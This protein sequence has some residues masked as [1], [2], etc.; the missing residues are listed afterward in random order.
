M[1]GANQ[2]SAAPART[3]LVVIDLSLK[4]VACN[5]DAIQI[6]TFPDNPE[7]ISDL[8]G[9]LTKKI[10]SCL[11]D[12]KSPTRPSFVAEFRSANRMHLCRAFPLTTGTSPNTRHPIVVLM[13]ERKSREQSTMVEI[14]KRFGLTPREQETA[15]LLGEGLTSKEIATRMNISPNTVN[16]FVRLMMVKMNVSSR[17]AIIGKIVAP[18]EWS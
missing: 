7:K 8:G 14:S 9:W 1:Q 5:A 2:M 16:S 17:S 10:H 6:L 11:V 13:L 15:R 3:G 18:K 4:L 12:Q